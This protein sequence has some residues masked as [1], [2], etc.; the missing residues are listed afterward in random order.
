MLNYTT[1]SILDK[2]KDY[3][4]V[5]FKPGPLNSIKEDKKKVII[6]DDAFAIVDTL[7]D[8]IKTIKDKK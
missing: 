2:E 6:S 8:L 3:N 5:T 7:K 4:P 1:Q